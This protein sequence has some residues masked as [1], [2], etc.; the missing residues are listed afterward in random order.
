MNE[1]QK[2]GTFVIPEEVAKELSDLLIKQTIRERVLVNV[3]DQPDKYKVAEENLIP[4]VSRIEAIKMNITK[5]YVPAEF[6]SSEYIWNYDGY[7]ISGTSV[8]VY[9]NEKDF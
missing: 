2:V 6:R 8:A 7:E 1:N 4:I 3:I 5:N 9:S